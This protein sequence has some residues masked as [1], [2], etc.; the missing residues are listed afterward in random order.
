MKLK[1]RFETCS[2]SPRNIDDFNECLKMFI[3]R[4]NALGPL[5]AKRSLEMKMGAK[6]DA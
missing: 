2:T 4:I 6:N 1:N 5:E 3:K